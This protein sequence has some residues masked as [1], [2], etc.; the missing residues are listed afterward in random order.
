MQDADGIDSEWEYFQLEQLLDDRLKPV[1]SALDNI[2]IKLVSECYLYK[3][4][5]ILTPYYYYYCHYLQDKLLQSSSD[6]LP[7]QP[8]T[9]EDKLDRLL[10]E[11]RELLKV[12]RVY[13]D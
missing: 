7:H 1:V 11:S 10:R 5:E 13:L 9:H 6:P 2:Q 12:I 4:P 3:F 8:T